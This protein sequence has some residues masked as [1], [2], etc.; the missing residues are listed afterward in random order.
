MPD[1]NLLEEQ[2][3]IKKNWT[4]AFRPSR[5]N[6]TVTTFY[7]LT[8]IDEQKYAEIAIMEGIGS[9]CSRSYSK[10]GITGLKND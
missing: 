9:V 6:Q 7:N 3:N 2:G 10:K 8:R 1:F 5:E 4:G